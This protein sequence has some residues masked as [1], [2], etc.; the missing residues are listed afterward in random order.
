MDCHTSHLI[1][2]FP[3][4]R[5]KSRLAKKTLA[6]LQNKTLNMQTLA[7]MA[8]DKGPDNDRNRSRVCQELCLVKFE[9]THNAARTAAGPKHSKLQRR[10]APVSTVKRGA[11]TLNG[12]AATAQ[13]GRIRPQLD[14][15]PVIPRALLVVAYALRDVACNGRA[16][17]SS[18]RYPDPEWREALDLVPFSRHAL[19]VRL[20]A[21]LVANLLTRSHETGFSLAQRCGVRCTSQYGCGTYVDTRSGLEGHASEKRVHCR[22]PSRASMCCYARRASL[23]TKGSRR[24]PG[25]VRLR[26][27]ARHCRRSKTQQGLQGWRYGEHKLR[28]KPIQGALLE[29]QF[30]RRNGGE[31]QRHLSPLLF[32]RLGPQW[33]V[34]M[35]CGTNCVLVV[36]GPAHH[37]LD[38]HQQ[39]MSESG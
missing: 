6:V 7:G 11:P 21:A 31:M 36:R 19:H 32:C 33:N 8:V 15:L 3:A 12:D 29:V 13:A 14:R 9:M 27:C 2:L 30:S 37:S 1:S 4:A 23:A 22:A 18:G 10:V 38:G 16:P 24:P 17:C 20:D 35:T 34:R 39:R 28:G 26:A 25:H 5:L